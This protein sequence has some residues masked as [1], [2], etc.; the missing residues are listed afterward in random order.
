MFINDQLKLFAHDK[1]LSGNIDASSGILV[2]WGLDEL[3][4]GNP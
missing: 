1:G 2:L 3:T 4:S